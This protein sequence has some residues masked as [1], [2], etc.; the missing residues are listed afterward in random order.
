MNVCSRAN[1]SSM[2]RAQLLATARQPESNG[3]DLF[4]VSRSKKEVDISPNTL[5]TYMKAGL[6]AYRMGKACFV[7]RSQLQQFIFANAGKQSA[8]IGQ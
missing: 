2:N 6:P 4:R 3:Y 1:V 7:S 5:R 8:R